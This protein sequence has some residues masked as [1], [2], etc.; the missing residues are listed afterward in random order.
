VVPRRM[1]VIGG[2]VVA[3]EA[4]TWLNG[5]G[6]EELTLIGAAPALLARNEPFAGEYVREELVARGVTVHLGA[7]VDRVERVAPEASGEGQIHG[8]EVTVHFGEQSVLVDE[9][10]VAVGRTPASRDLGLETV[11]LIGG[12]ALDATV[13]ANH[14]HIAVDDHFAVQG[15]GGEWLYAIG[16]IVGRAQLTHMGKYHARICG[17]VLAARAD[18]RS[19]DGPWFRDVADDG[20]VPQV[21]FTDPQVASV[22][23]TEQ[24]A[25]DSGRPVKAVEYDLGALAG[26]YV[27]RDG[28]KGRAKI[29]VD[30]STSTLVGATFVGP[31]V[32]DL[33]HAATIAIIGQVT[34]E[35]LWHAVPSYPTPS[36]IWLRLLETYFNPV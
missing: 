18:G 36:E 12:G 25:R 9:L 15:V 17:S 6:V 23:L 24:E 31:E 26:T 13:T 29:V 11:D 19:I 32:S 21:T 4:A 1:A 8:G 22:G 2:G 30:T 28:Y 35:Q 3:C 34:L 5:L 14:G 10:L 33:V 27:M 20:V 16:D 7:S